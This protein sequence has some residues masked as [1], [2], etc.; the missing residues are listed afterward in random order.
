[1]E[2]EE[3]RERDL[4]MFPFNPLN[5][6]EPRVIVRDLAD[7]LPELFSTPG[8]SSRPTLRGKL[9]PLTIFLHPAWT[10]YT[11]RHRQ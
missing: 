9:A 4:R 8:V 10:W 7:F 6:V 1:M 3:E 2:R 11:Q 5:H